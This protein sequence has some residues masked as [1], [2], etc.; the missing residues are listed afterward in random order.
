MLERI[1]KKLPIKGADLPTEWEEYGVG[2]GQELVIETQEGRR[3]HS[4]RS[5]RKLAQ[6]QR[7][8]L[9]KRT[10]RSIVVQQIDQAQ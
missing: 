3:K 1:V 4:V 5:A 7:Q 10:I 2:P 6:L 8:T 9:A